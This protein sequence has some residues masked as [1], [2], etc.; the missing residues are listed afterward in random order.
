[1]IRFGMKN[2]CAALA[3]T[4]C[5]ALMARAAA[6]ETFVIPTPQKMRWLEGG[7]ALANADGSAAACLWAPEDCPPAIEY[8]LARF[9]SAVSELGGPILPVRRGAAP[10]NKLAVIAID[11]MGGGPLGSELVKT[12]ALGMDETYPGA[13]GYFIKFLDHAGSETVL[14][15]GADARGAYYAVETFVQMLYKGDG[16]EVRLRRADIEDWPAF[17]MRVA[18]SAAQMGLDAIRYL[19]RFKLHI[20]G[21]HYP[22]LRHWKTP[23]PEYADRVREACEFARDT[24]IV[25]I[26]QYI[27]PYGNPMHGD[28]DKYRLNACNADEMNLLI[29]AFELSLAH[30]GKHIMLCVDDF[31][32]ENMLTPEESAVFGPKGGRYGVRLGIQAFLANEVHA[33]LKA[34]YPDYSMLFCPQPYHNLDK[35]ALDWYAALAETVSK[36]IGLVWTGPEIR[37]HLITAE[38]M[39]MF[40]ENTGIK[41]FYWDNTIYNAHNPAL[42]MC[43]VDPFMLGNDYPE[44]FYDMLYNSGVHINSFAFEFYRISLVTAADYLWNPEA[45]DPHASLERA[46]I[47]YAGFE[48]GPLL[49]RYRELLIEALV[50]LGVTGR[51]KEPLPDNRRLPEIARP[52]REIAGDLVDVRRK[53]S[54]FER[55]DERMPGLF[56]PYNAV[57]DEPA[58]E[59]ELV[60]VPGSNTIHSTEMKQDE[61]GLIVEISEEIAD[62]VPADAKK[63]AFKVLSLSDT[64]PGFETH[65]LSPFHALGRLVVDFE[66]FMLLSVSRDVS[67]LGGGG[68]SYIV[69]FNGLFTQAEW[70]TV[71]PADAKNPFLCMVMADN[72]FNAERSKHSVELLVNGRVVHSHFLGGGTVLN[73]RLVRASLDESLAT[74]GKEMVVELRLVSGVSEKTP[75]RVVATPIYLVFGGK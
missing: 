72:L 6:P 4:V 20:Q 36:D 17:K 43:L 21:F 60:S 47:R 56:W 61:V 38:D 33:R 31:F 8:A 12:H 25:D 18:P 26:I 59:I 15:M 55:V 62:L 13:E 30:G 71:L 66:D 39:E 68:M 7:L 42:T 35:D 74:P 2:C 49:V 75:C 16:G 54:A 73:P 45:Y 41:P 48:A 24:G 51:R 57:S 53:L 50:N 1:M 29:K 52:L 9:Q 10:D 22:A 28:R 40:I 14:C 65:T 3:L 46:A 11:C 23:D 44:K 70:R 63:N 19:A 37:S 67:G 58:A 64:G 27:N 5:A 34:R 69:R 32:K